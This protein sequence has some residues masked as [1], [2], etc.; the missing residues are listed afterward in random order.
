MNE[1]LL[2]RMHKK[3]NKSLLRQGL[4]HSLSE[5]GHAVPFSPQDFGSLCQFVRLIHNTADTA[6]PSLHQDRNVSAVFLFLLQKE[7]SGMFS[8]MTLAIMDILKS[9]SMEV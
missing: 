9:R 1:N 2:C 5:S 6:G 4:R 8:D 3:A 7:T